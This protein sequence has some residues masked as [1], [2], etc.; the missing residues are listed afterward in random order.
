M[1]VPINRPSPLV[2]ESEYHD[3]LRHS[4][5]STETNVDLIACVFSHSAQTHG[6]TQTHTKL[7]THCPESLSMKGEEV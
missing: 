5:I 6:C 2:V 4:C 7:H 3:N 1:N